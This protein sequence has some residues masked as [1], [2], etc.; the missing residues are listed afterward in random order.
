MS[1]RNRKKTGKWEGIEIKDHYTQVDYRPPESELP[2]VS[3]GLDIRTLNR[4]LT[5]RT[6][7]EKATMWTVYARANINFAKVKA[8]KKYGDSSKFLEFLPNFLMLSKYFMYYPCLIVGYG[9]SFHDNLGRFKE[10]PRDK[11]RMIASERCLPEMY[12]NGVMP[13][14]VVN[15]DSGDQ[16]KHFFFGTP[17]VY[18][19]HL[20]GIG[21]VK[22]VREDFYEPTELGKRTPISDPTKATQ[23]N[24]KGDISHWINHEYGFI[25]ARHRVL[26]KYVLDG[27]SNI[28]ELAKILNVYPDKP[29]PTNNLTGIFAITSNPDIR[30]WFRGKIYW[31]NP[32]IYPWKNTITWDFQQET[33]LGA[34]P[35]GGN[36]GTTSLALG[37]ALGSEPL[38][39]LGIDYCHRP[40]DFDPSKLSVVEY[41]SF[42]PKCGTAHRATIRASDDLP[43]KCICQ[44][45]TCGEIYE[46]RDPACKTV[47]TN[48]SYKA[49]AFSMKQ[50]LT[51][52]VYKPLFDKA[53]VYNLSGGIL[54]G[55]FVK[56]TTFDNFKNALIKWDAKK[57]FE[58][59]KAEMQKTGRKSHMYGFTMTHCSFEDETG[60][61]F[62]KD[63][64]KVK[65]D[66]PFEIEEGV[67]FRHEETNAPGV[68]KIVSAAE[69]VREE[70]HEVS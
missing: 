21:A 54:H 45:S 61:Y 8:I 16:I 39:L 14:V 23:E 47:C 65:S 38:F 41:Q 15:L 18:L 43:E 68:A 7:A 25:D 58:R 40:F 17:R 31:Y 44:K 51:S 22:Q 3:R 64:V 50:L 67:E 4:E 6:L 12:Y 57:E 55:N 20:V 36:V 2:K 48:T 69:P 66:A 5:K 26:M 19:S 30:K 42:C 60:K 32:T 62:I 28:N 53:R 35:T 46:P 37:L 24:W 1:H 13:D 59:I 70:K 34:I 27:V 52:E 33:R 29:V 56:R 10:L 49:Y 11:C 63:G 9:P